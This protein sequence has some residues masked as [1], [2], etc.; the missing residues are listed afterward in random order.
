MEQFLSTAVLPNVTLHL[1]GGGFD[2]RTLAEW[3]DYYRVPVPYLFAFLT[4]F[5]AQWG[6][7]VIELNNKYL[8]AR[9]PIADFL[10]SDIAGCILFSNDIVARFFHDTLQLRNWLG[11]PV[12]SIQQHKIL[13]ASTGYAVR[14]YLFGK[15]VRPF[16]YMG[17]TY[18]LGLAVQVGERDYLSLGAGVAVTKAFDTAHDSRSDYLNKIRVSGGI[19]GT[20]TTR[21]S[22]H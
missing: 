6:N 19:S 20:G 8:N 9:D 22:F 11:Q 17:M 5:A 21:S 1:I 18:L 7:E 2:F 10:F 14:P 12:Y 13:N 15:T 16:L 4:F 3:Y